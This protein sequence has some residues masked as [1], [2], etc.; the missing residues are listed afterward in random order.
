MDLTN[1]S[2]KTLKLQSQ[3]PDSIAATADQRIGF[4]MD[5][6]CRLMLWHLPS[7]QYIGVLDNCAKS[8]ARGVRSCVHS[9]VWIAEDE[10]RISVLTQSDSLPAIKSWTLK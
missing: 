5:I 9:E 3:F 6:D 2:Y 1:G 7:W 10:S 8:A 4:V